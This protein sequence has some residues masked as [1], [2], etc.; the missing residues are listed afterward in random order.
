MSPSR[1]NVASAGTI[2]PVIRLDLYSGGHILHRGITSSKGTWIQLL[3]ARSFILVEV[4]LS[5]GV[6]FTLLLSV[7]VPLS[8]SN[9]AMR[10]DRCFAPQSELR[11]PRYRRSLGALIDFA[12][13]AAGPDRGIQEK[14]LGL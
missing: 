13:L 1:L 8:G 5:V 11:V 7:L 4:G 10:V 2:R 14:D 6:V 12:D 9:V 3:I